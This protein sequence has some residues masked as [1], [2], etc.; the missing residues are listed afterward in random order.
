[1]LHEVLVARGAPLEQLLGQLDL[2]LQ[3][4]DLGCIAA[5][6]GTVGGLVDVPG[7]IGLKEGEEGVT[8]CC[9]D[10][11]SIVVAVQFKP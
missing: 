5:H 8:P 3:G 9:V 10:R 1:M 11:G 7:A 6:C 4:L 2:R